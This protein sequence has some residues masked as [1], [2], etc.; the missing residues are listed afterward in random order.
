M[1]AE[2]VPLRTLCECPWQTRCVLG[3]AE[4][5][6]EGT[7]HGGGRSVPDFT[8]VII[9][10]TIIIIINIIITKYHCYYY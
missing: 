10:I 9:I 5:P 2:E 4:P 8:F 7:K 6:S 3:A 1:Q